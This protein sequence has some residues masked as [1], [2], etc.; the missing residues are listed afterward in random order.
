LEN[1]G[2]VEEDLEKTFNAGVEIGIGPAKLK[3]IISYL[4]KTYCGHIG[5]EFMYILDPEKKQ[6]LTERME[7]TQNTPNFSIE[8]KRR[9]LEKLN[10]ATIFENFLHTK[11]I[12]QKRFSL[13]GLEGLIPALDTLI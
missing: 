5:A 9:I 4:H 13:E 2:L 1:F 6:W 8:E 3:D 10:Q 11:Y 12:G 7:S